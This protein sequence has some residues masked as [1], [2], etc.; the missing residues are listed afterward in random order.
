MVSIV[1]V[2]EP[3]DGELHTASNFVEALHKAKTDV[4]KRSLIEKLR[5]FQF[6]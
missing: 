3:K 4:T 1:A 6:M 2:E 5:D